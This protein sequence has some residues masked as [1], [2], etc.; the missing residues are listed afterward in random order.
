MSSTK[1]KWSHV[2]S[3]RGS[4]STSLVT[5]VVIFDSHGADL[6]AGLCHVSL[7]PRLQ[8]RLLRTGHPGRLLRTGHVRHRV[9]GT[10]V[11]ICKI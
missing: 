11:D 8:G 7:L 4:D 9:T 2:D 5:T 10:D 1:E 3:L 6:Q